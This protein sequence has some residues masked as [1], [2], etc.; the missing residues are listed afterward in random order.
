MIA[1]IGILV[2][3]LLPA[4]QSAREAARR[5]QCTNQVKQ[6]ALAMHNYESAHREL[7]PGADCEGVGVIW[8]C[9]TWLEYLLPYIEQEAVHSRLDFDLQNDAP[10]NQQA[11]NDLVIPGLMC[12]SDE[13]AGLFNNS[14]EPVYLPGPAGTYSLG[15]SYIPS[16]GPL[17]M[18][19][20][21]APAVRHNHQVINCQRDRGGAIGIGTAKPWGAPGMFSG[22]PNRY[23]FKQCTDGLS[24]TL[25]VGET[26]PA[27]NS[28]HMYFA[29]HMNVATTH[30]PINYH[31][32]DL[33]CT[34]TPD[35][36]SP[37]DCYAKMAGFKSLHPSGVVMARADCSVEFLQDDTDYKIFQF[38]GD[39][40]DGESAS[41]DN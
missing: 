36:R 24:N 4:V 35:V 15:M 11:L 40:A 17:K 38:L 1:I 39:K 30:A 20:C 31:Q 8:H 2:G 29:S 22:G 10:V 18:N 37:G 5:T 26:L 7:P 9:H 13:D 28:F 23:R 12:P 3:L 21:F 32:I 14:R 33:S 27:Y 34:K 6:V 41:L 19:F 16:G 25:L